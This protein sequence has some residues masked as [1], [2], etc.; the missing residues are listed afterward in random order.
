MVKFLRSQEMKEEI[1]H[2]V[3]LIKLPS[4]EASTHYW[5]GW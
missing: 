2:Y 1:K 5:L 3:M 4:Q